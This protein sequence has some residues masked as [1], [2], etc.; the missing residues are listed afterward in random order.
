MEEKVD[1]PTKKVGK[2]TKEVGTRPKKVATSRV[3]AAAAARIKSLALSQ[4]G[5]SLSEGHASVAELLRIL[6]IKESAATVPPV[7]PLLPDEWRL[8]RE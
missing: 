8:S 7:Q 4:L 2:D 6:A 1:T 3:D 5:A